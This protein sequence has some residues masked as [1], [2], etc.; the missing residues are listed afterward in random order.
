MSE[1]AEGFTSLGFREVSR[2]TLDEEVQG[3]LLRFDVSFENV[4]VV[5]DTVIKF[6]GARLFLVSLAVA[7]TLL[8][9]LRADRAKTSRVT[10]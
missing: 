6:A 4:T 3:Y 5:F 1:L 10:H 2:M 7:E 9:S 8:D